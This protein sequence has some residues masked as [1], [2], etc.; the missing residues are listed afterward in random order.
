MKERPRLAKI[1]EDLSK[2]A[3][4][5]TT[6]VWTATNLEIAQLEAVVEAAAAAVEAQAAS[7]A[8]S[9]DT[10]LGTVLNQDVA[11]NFAFL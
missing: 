3:T 4:V 2:E 9:L 11:A 5:A 7:I 1:L 10:C 6:A 8:A